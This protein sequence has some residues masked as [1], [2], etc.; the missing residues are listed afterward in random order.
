MEDFELTVSLFIR[1]Q[2]H[3]NRVYG[4][5]LQRLRHDIDNLGELNEQ[6]TVHI[7]GILGKNKIIY[8]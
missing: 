5:L 3:F 4:G 6:D 8:M 2:A 1:Y 7:C